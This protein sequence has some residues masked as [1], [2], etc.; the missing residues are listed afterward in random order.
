MLM[1]YDGQQLLKLRRL[2]L[3]WTAVASEREVKFTLLFP[4]IEAS[5]QL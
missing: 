2:P 5:L 3:Q 4:G 1:V